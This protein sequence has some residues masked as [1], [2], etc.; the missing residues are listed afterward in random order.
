MAMTFDAAL[1]S[2]TGNDRMRMGMAFLHKE[3]SQQKQR[4]EIHIIATAASTRPAPITV[5]KISIISR[6]GNGYCVACDRLGRMDGNLFWQYLRF[7]EQQPPHSGCVVSCNNNNNNKS[8]SYRLS[9]STPSRVLIAD[10]GHVL[11]TLVRRTVMQ[12]IVLSWMHRSS[13][14]RPPP[15]PSHHPDVTCPIKV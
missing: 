6:N 4:R 11:L 12:H 1:S 13:G 7:S 15:A 2:C 9:Q 3:M 10:D 14:F 5:N 8:I